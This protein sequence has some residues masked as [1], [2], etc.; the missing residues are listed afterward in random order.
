MGVLQ[1]IYNTNNCA[2]AVQNSMKAGGLQVSD[3]GYIRD[4]WENYKKGERT[5]SI[6][7]QTYRYIMKANRGIL[8][9]PTKK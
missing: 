5:S 4:F 3:Y 8:I 1:R 9:T 7:S 2:T 6:P